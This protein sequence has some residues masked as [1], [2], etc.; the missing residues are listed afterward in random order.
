MQRVKIQQTIRNCSTSLQFL[1]QLH[2]AAHSFVSFEVSVLQFY[3]SENTDEMM[4][5]PLFKFSF[6]R[7]YLDSLKYRNGIKT[8]SFPFLCPLLSFLFFSF[9]VSTYDTLKHTERGS[10]FIAASSPDWVH[11]ISSLKQVPTFL[12]S[13]TRQLDSKELLYTA[14]SEVLVRL[15]FYFVYTQAKHLKFIEV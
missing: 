6:D 10:Q 13:H 12:L 8:L 14:L 15:S 1:Q 5:D 9:I 2:F 3:Q 4:D 11:H 7:G